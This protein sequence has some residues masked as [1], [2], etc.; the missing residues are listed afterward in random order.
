[1]RVDQGLLRLAQRGEVDGRGR[2]GGRDARR[3][4][5]QPPPQAAAIFGLSAVI[6]QQAFGERTRARRDPGQ[7][8]QLSG[9]VGCETL[10]SREDLGRGGVVRQ[11]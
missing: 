8:P 9:D 10:D 1:M 6:G 11:K 3:R 2:G 7:T 5:S 4:Q